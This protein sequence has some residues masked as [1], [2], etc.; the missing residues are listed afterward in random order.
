MSKPEFD[1]C[2]IG[3]GSGGLTCAA[4]GAAL[5]ARVALIEKHRIGGECL[6]TGC[7][8]SKALIHSAK[9]AHTVRTAGQAAIG[10]QA[11]TVSLAQV[12]EKVRRTIGVIEPHDSPERFR[13]MGIDVIFGAGRFTDPKTFTVAGRAV[14]AR[15][16]VL[17]TGSR[18]A[19][20][21]IAGL[22]RVPYLTNENLFDLR[23]D[24]P[25]LIVIG[26]GAIGLEMG[27]AFCRLGSRV[28]II[29]RSDAILSREDPDLNAVLRERMAAEGTEFHLGRAIERV[30][31]EAGALRVLVRPGDGDAY[32]IEGSHLLVAIGRKANTDGLGLEAAGV[33]MAN[34][35]P[36]LD[37]RL[38]TSNRRIY[39]C[40]DVAGPH[41]FSHMAEHQGGVVLQNALFGLPAKVE[42]RV[43]P[44]AVFTEPEFARVGLSE[45]EAR[46]RGIGHRVYSL[47][48]EG[49]DRA[50]ADDDRA[51]LAKL[52]TD[53]KGRLLGAAI[54]GPHAG[55]LIHEYITV[56]ANGL[57]V[58]ALGAGIHI[59]PTLSQIGPRLAMTHRKAGLKP[60]IKTAMKHIFGLRGPALPVSEQEEIHV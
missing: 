47:P 8:P 23:E 29:N 60:W 15:K 17:A 2:V 11:P 3:A 14:T 56:M 43:I 41:L 13:G 38:R 39:A 19:A 36:V 28:S 51:G 55:E 44:Y 21:P 32:W 20:P 49:N 54:V 35:R 52:I 10:A 12:M 30:E 22:D 26:A 6:W 1:L 31:G 7:V 5:G 33:R 50:I 18:P 16:F 34:G 25:H 53:P 42:S 58:G 40:G 46:R 59:Y 4:G 45:T 57:K 27:Q 9:V 48:F 37:A 24:V